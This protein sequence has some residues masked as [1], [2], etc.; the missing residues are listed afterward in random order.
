MMDRIE[1]KSPLLVDEYRGMFGA[2]AILGEIEKVIS[3]R[4]AKGRELVR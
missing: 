1:S 4:I 2:L 3:Y